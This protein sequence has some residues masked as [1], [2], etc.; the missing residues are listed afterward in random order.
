MWGALESEPADLIETLKLR[1]VFELP[2]G[3]HPDLNEVLGCS[4]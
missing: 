1:R 4:G 2:A 3:Y